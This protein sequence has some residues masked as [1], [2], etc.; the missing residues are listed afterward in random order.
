VILLDA[1]L[2]IY[3]VDA[4]SSHHG[5]AKPWLERALS[6]AE[7]V[8]IPWVVL[9][10]F[11]RITTREGIL[12]R[13]LTLSEAVEY[14]DSWLAQPNVEAVSPGPAHWSIVRALILASGTAGNLTTDAHLAAM[15]IERGATLWSTDNDF[16]RFQGLNHRNPLD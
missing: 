4:D 12:T 10:A 15:A 1:N 7:P 6:G 9:M 16:K 3:A 11:L 2:L 14:I 8:A 5:V 13:T